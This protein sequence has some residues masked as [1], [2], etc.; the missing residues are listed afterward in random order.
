V[1]DAYRDAAARWARAE[2]LAEY[3]ERVRATD[4]IELATYRPETAAYGERALLATAEAHFAES[5]AFA[6][7]LLRGRLPAGGRRAVALA[8][9]ML[10][11]AVCEPRAADAAR[12]VERTDGDTVDPRLREQARQLWAAA[13]AGAGTALGGE[14]AAWLRS[15]Q[16]LHA[17][18]AAAARDGGFAPTETGSPLGHLAVCAAPGH[19]PVAAVVLRCTHLLFNRLGVHGAAEA[20]IARM[21]AGA[22]TGLDEEERACRQQPGTAPTSTTTSSTRTP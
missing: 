13:D 5:S 1:L 8:A 11:L 17:T 19:R 22:L 10:A 7:R 3:D 2:R 16:T 21:A 4:G 9:L 15:V 14:L 20:Q 6:M 18:L 12:R